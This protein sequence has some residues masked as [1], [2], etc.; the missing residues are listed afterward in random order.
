MFTAKQLTR[1]VCA[2]SVLRR[3]NKLIYYSIFVHLNLLHKQ[4]IID[5][6][7]EMK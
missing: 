5:L 7:S 3:T 4:L 6:S 2:E 1:N